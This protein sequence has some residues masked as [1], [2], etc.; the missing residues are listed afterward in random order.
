MTIEPAQT[1]DPQTFNAGIFRCTPELF[2]DL[3]QL[4]A[5]SH[6]DAVWIAQ[7][8]PGVVEFRVRGPAW[9]KVHLGHHI[10][11]VTAT[12]TQSTNADG[13]TAYRVEW[14]PL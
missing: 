11:Q 14:S 5:G 7:D 8:C 2:A 13:M 9:P 12:F 1:E 4:P 3:L 6:V 10:P